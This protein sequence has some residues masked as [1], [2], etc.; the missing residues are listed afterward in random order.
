[1]LALTWVHSDTGVKVPLHELGEVRPLVVLDGVHA[2]GVEDQPLD[3]VCDVFVAGTHK[4]LGGPRGT[5]CS[6]RRCTSTRP[7][8]TRP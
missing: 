5:G 3:K 7:A 6:G 1:M 8:S 4:W 2:L